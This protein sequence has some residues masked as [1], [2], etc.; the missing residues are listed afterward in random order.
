MSYQVLSNGAALVPAVNGTYTA[1]GPIRFG[2]LQ[3]NISGAPAAGDTFKIATAKNA[4]TDVFEAISDLV[5]ALR[6]PLTGG[7][8]AAQA[9]LSNALNTA[10]S[11]ITNAQDNVLTIRA[12]VGSRML[13][14]DALNTSGASRDLIDKS[15]LSELQDLDYSKAIS[16]F[17]QRE[18]SLKATLQT[19]AKLN[20]IALFNYL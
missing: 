8:A 2:G 11:K 14:L 16:E 12:S 4:G 7:G 3:I 18:T 13:E 9:Q 20:S 19:F 6:K 1:G 5:N 10:S 17:S 15:Y